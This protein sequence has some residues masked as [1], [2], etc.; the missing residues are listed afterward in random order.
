MKRS[1]FMAICLLIASM[2]IAQPVIQ[3]PANTPVIGDESAVQFVVTH[4]ISLDPTGANSTWDYSQLI[5]DTLSGIIRAVDPS[6]APSGDLFPDADL[7]LMLGNNVS[8]C[9]VTEDGVFYLGATMSVMG[10]NATLVYSDSRQYIKYPFGFE[11]VY[12]DLYKGSSSV[13]TYEVKVSGESFV[14]ADAYG[15]LIMPNGTYEN[16]IR[17][18]SMDIE[19]DSIFIAGTFFQEMLNSHWQFSWYTAWSHFPVFTIEI[20]DYFG[21]SDTIA[22][23][24]TTGA[25]IPAITNYDISDLIIYPNPAEDV[26]SLE[27][28]MGEHH[29]A[30]ISIVNQIGQLMINRTFHSTQGVV[31]EE[32]DIS[33]LPS[34]IYFVNL[35]CDCGQHQ[36]RKLIIR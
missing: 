17:V 14:S 36:T 9:S 19:T 16:V 24:A 5:N 29:A 10:Y 35:N 13:A 25:G 4:G 32:I 23:Y 28:S 1:L 20:S 6:E 18:A 15:T 8:Y 33:K 21:N 30:N 22:Y 2:V 11:N 12:T 27:F 7:A 31:S 34:G 26:L 3:Y